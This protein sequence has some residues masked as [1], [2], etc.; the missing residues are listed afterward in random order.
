MISKLRTGFL[1]A[2][3]I[4]GGGLYAQPTRTAAERDA[5]IESL[6]AVESLEP[7]DNYTEVLA[8][9]P[10][11]FMFPRT[12]PNQERDTGPKFTDSQILRRVG[13]TLRPQ[14][15]GIIGR[16]DTFFIQT[17]GGSLMRQGQR[18]GVTVRQLSDNQIE[19]EIGEIS[20]DGFTLKY[21]DTEAYFPFYE[22]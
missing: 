11:P 15:R 20:N 17:A 5:I 6:R 14:I 13:I 18:F 19:I 3:C 4:L 10:S 1:I 7:K 16:G 12:V 9:I 8:L 2:A 21:K 22:E